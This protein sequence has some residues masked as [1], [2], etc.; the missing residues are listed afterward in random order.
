[1]SRL[2]FGGSGFS[3]AAAAA[4]GADFLTVG[5]FAGALFAGAVATGTAA[6]ALAMGR[7][8]RV[9]G[10]TNSRNPLSAATTSRE[11]LAIATQFNTH[12]SAT[13]D[14]DSA[15]PSCHQCATL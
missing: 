9:L 10:I 3:S 5:V 6:A 7:S 4:A 11:T 12:Q 14:R 2:G 13:K 15:R 8:S 1:M